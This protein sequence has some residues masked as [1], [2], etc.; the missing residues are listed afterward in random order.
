MRTFLIPIPSTLFEP[1]KYEYSL[2]LNGKFDSLYFKNDKLDIDLKHRSM[3]RHTEIDCDEPGCY[4][5]NEETEEIDF[6]SGKE[7]YFKTKTW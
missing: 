1:A 2:N 3:S 5:F 7:I 6:F 4:Y